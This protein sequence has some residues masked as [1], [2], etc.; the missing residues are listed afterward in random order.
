M[1]TYDTTKGKTPTGRNRQQVKGKHKP[2][3]KPFPKKGVDPELD[4]KRDAAR[5]AAYENGS[6]E[7]GAMANKEMAKYRRKSYWNDQVMKYLSK[8]GNEN[9]GLDILNEI[10]R[11]LQS[12]SSDNTRKELI[13]IKS[14][15]LGFSAPAISVE[16]D[17]PEDKQEG[18][19][20]SLDKLAALGFDTS[21]VRVLEDGQIVT[22]EEN[23]DDSV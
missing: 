22:G 11:I 7:K 3:G 20:A 17:E 9:A 1:G 10:D 21:S 14:Q 2:R 19:Q 23:G 13:K 8:D 6:R 18:V 5:E 16:A 15:I 12:T 4:A